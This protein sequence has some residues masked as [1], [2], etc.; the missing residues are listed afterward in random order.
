MHRDIRT[1]RGGQGVE[2]VGDLL[3][4]LVGAVERRAEDGHDADRVLV[5]ELQGLLGVELQAALLDGGVPGLD[6][7]VAAELLPHDLDVDP[8]HE[9]RLV[10]GEARRLA[11]LAPAPLQR[12]PAEHDGLARAGRR[13]PGGLLVAR[14]VPQVR[15]DLH[16]AALDRGRLRV[17][18]L[19]DHVLVQRLGHE[20]V[21]L[22][23]HERRDERREVLPGVAV[24][25]ELVVE[26]A[27]GHAW[28][29]ALSGQCVLGDPGQF[30]RAGVDGGDG[31]ALE[32]EHLLGVDGHGH[33]LAREANAGKNRKR[34]WG[35]ATVAGR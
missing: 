1:A 30:V 3:D 4:R 34:P 11:A 12:Q 5:D 35:G 19:V 14:G 28:I 18:V 23:V 25:H 16:A 26:Q 32:L 10:R 7:P 31:Q 33:T 15:D 2:G 8:H 9:V 21:G 24:E 22:L 27:V 20:P 6:V 29:H 17:L 13:R